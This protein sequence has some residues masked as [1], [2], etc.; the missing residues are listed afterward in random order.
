MFHVRVQDDGTFTIT[1]DEGIEI[2]LGPRRLFAFFSQ[3]HPE[4]AHPSQAHAP[5]T[6]RSSPQATS[7]PPGSFLSF[8]GA[9]ASPGWVSAR[10]GD[11]H[12]LNGAAPG[13]SAPAAPGWLRNAASLSALGGSTAGARGGAGESLE[14]GEGGGERLVVG[15]F[16]A[17]R[18]DGV[19]VRHPNPEP[20]H[21]EPERLLLLLLYSRYRS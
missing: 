5:A 6:A 13:G 18:A 14:E 16:A 19:G 1:Y 2:R 17:V 10:G 7:A 20:P 12:A 11:R 8:C 4:E 3:A 9:T 15:C 21:P